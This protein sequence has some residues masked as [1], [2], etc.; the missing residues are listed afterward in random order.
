[1][2]MIELSGT[3]FCKFS[4]SNIVHN[5]LM[6]IKTDKYTHIYST[7]NTQGPVSDSQKDDNEVLCPTKGGNYFFS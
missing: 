7:V 4:F 1:V 2:S 3:Q 5:K 6:L